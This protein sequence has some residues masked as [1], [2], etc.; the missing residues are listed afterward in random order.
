MKSFSKLLEFLFEQEEYSTN[1]HNAD[2]VMNEPGRK[3]IPHEEM[4]LFKNE[5]S[6]NILAV[7]K[8]ASKEEIDYWSNWYQYAHGHVKELAT[9]YD[10]PV[11]VSAAV[12]A[13]LSPN[14]SWK[15][16]LMSAD[17][18]MKAWEDGIEEPSGIPAYKT[19][20]RKAMKI[21]NTG[22]IG[23]VNGPKVSVFFDSLMNPEKVQN[24]LVLD[25]HAI[26]VWRGIKTPLKNMSSPTKVERKAIIQD[27][28]KVADL[29]GLTPQGLQA[30]TWY[31]WKAVK[32]PP[33][34]TGTFEVEQPEIREARRS[35]AA[36]IQETIRA[37]LQEV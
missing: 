3:K 30:V 22:N 32:N 26:N 12:C 6:H 25:G 5:G 31:I 19:N 1:A 15:L 14:L 20:V 21:L 17:R 34:I 11:P 35:L 27:Y 2:Y 29:V 28:M 8:K 24:E 37:I 18:V 4:N 23:Y 16:N 36:I 10:I 13:V 7:L 33:K 9:K